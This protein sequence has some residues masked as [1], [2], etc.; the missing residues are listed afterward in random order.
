MRISEDTEGRW[1]FFPDGTEFGDFE[2]FAYPK[3][4]SDSDKAILDSLGYYD[5][6]NQDAQWDWNFIAQHMPD[7]EVLIVVTGG[8]EKQRY[9]TYG[10]VA[11]T[12]EGEIARFESGEVLR[13][14]KELG[15]TATQPW[16]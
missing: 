4:P 13:R 3:D 10:E 16:Y 15:L 14:I 2:E 6:D 8:A 12:N 5:L 11:Y 1:A 9:I 7:K